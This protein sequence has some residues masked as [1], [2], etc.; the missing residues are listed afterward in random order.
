MVAE[1]FAVLMSLF[2]LYML[3]GLVVS[4]YRDVILQKYDDIFMTWPKLLNPRRGINQAYKEGYSDMRRFGSLDH[5]MKGR[6][7][8][9]FMSHKREKIYDAYIKGGDDYL[10]ELFK[11]RAGTSTRKIRESML[12]SKDKART[13]ALK[14]IE[15]IKNGWQNE[16]DALNSQYELENARIPARKKHILGRKNKN[17]WS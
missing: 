14:A 10:E 3:V 9:K 8:D 6:C 11:D 4:F 17:V 5:P 1:F 12:E 7:D 15:E 13:E 16:Y 2:L